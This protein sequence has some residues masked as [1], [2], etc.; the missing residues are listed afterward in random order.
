MGCALQGSG[1]VVLLGG[2][3]GCQFLNQSVRVSQLF[4]AVPPRCCLYTKTPGWQAVA[5]VRNSYRPGSRAR[6]TF[7]FI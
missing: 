4:H 3:V 7:V 1:A 2:V 5:R 6:P